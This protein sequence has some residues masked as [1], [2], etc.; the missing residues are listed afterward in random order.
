MS[1]EEALFALEK[2]GDISGLIEHIENNPVVA[3]R[4]RAA[5]V[6]GDLEIQD[7][8]LQEKRVNILIKTAVGDRSQKV[9]K[10][11][12][13]SL[14]WSA[15]IDKVRRLIGKYETENDTKLSQDDDDRA[16]TEFLINAL[17][18]ESPVIRIVAALGL[19]HIGE[20]RALKPLIHA[21]DDNDPKV[22]E[23]VARS[24]GSLGDERAVEPL[25]GLLDDPNQEVRRQAT[26]SL[27]DIGSKKGVEDLI[28]ALNDEYLYVRKTAAY[29]LGSVGGEEVIDPLLDSL[30]D[31]EVLVRESITIALIEILS[32]APVEES[33][34][35]REKI[36]SR[37]EDLDTEMGVAP[38]VSALEE[39]SQAPIR[40]NAA[41]LLGHIGNRRMIDPLIDALEDDDQQVRRLAA[42]SLTE[43]GQ[44][45]VYHLT[46]ALRHREPEVRKMAAFA[47]GKIGAK[48]AVGDLNRM[49]REERNEDVRNFASSAVN[50][51]T[52]DRS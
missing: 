22:R 16:S 34:R 25:T 31:D 43:I 50:K 35:I 38:V 39:S 5:E 46:D 28:K 23:N 52:S 37:L 15:D 17:D 30:T 41:W 11:A 27:K 2:D 49:I 13:E 47:L 51:I 14:V 42:T 33:H 10:A 36:A 21:L 6:I 3:A 44:P 20:K 19:G 9:R 4:T 29:A 32:K 48:K 7:E 12:A 18:S 24:L 45:A 40:R 26:V 8:D 1:S